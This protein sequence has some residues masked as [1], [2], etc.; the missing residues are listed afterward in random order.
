MGLEDHYWVNVQNPSYFPVNMDPM[1]SKK[2][3][4]HWVVQPAYPLNDLRQRGILVIAH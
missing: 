1:V 3:I 2:S 4:Y